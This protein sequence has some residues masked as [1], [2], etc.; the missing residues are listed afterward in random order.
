[1]TQLQAHLGHKSITRQG[2][3]VASLHGMRM[4]LFLAGILIGKAI[5][6]LWQCLDIPGFFGTVR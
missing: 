6:V 1:M 3:A 4:F 2:L 5:A